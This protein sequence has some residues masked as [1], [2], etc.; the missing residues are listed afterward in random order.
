[1][2]VRI[3]NNSIR[4]RLKEP[5]VNLFKNTGT[6]TETLEFGSGD[7]EQLKFSLQKTNDDNIDLRFHNYHTIILVPAQLAEEWTITELVGFD[8]EIGNAKGKKICILVEK[9]FMCMDGREEENVGSYPNPL[10]GM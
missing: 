7:T 5:E 4:V 6:I 1:M 9:D 2:K 3:S 8:S 10:A